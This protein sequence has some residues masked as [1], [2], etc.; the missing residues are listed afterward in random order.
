M[1]PFELA[2]EYPLNDVLPEFGTALEV[3]PGVRWVRL[4][5][6]FALDHINVWLIRDS[7]D[8][9]DGWTLV[10]CGVARD[11]LKAIWQQVF[12]QAL[13]G[14][15]IVRI[16]ATHMH[17]D[18]VGLADWIGGRFG[19][20]LWMTL[21]EYTTARLYSEG[22]VQGGAT[23]GERSAAFYRLHGLTDPDALD[24]IRARAAY[25]SSLVPRVPP[26][27]RRIMHG[28]HIQ[29]GGYT[30]RVKVG[31]GHSPEHASLFCEELN[32]L[33]SGDMV[34]PR[35]SSNVSVHDDEPD[36]NPVELYLASLD[37]YDDIP[38]DA[39]ILPSH[40]KPFRGVHIRIEQQRQH[41]AERLAEVRAA[42]ATPKT[43]MEIVPLMFTRRLDLHQLTFALGEAV[44]HLNLLYYAGELERIRE[45]GTIR[46]MAA[47]R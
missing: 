25:Y 6:P 13:D 45:N 37:T 9:R 34:L 10:D 15:P 32:T 21:S 23:G 27:F 39:L 40:G 35:I 4:P 14:L 30:W 29:I 1:N 38:A 5:L 18:H 16:I 31:Y 8:G 36:G 3:A 42:C 47:A 43:A 44:A 28:D 11:E 26:S 41:H 7:F 19:A 33:I 46:F 20:P 12:A 22:R 17:P 2:L 24:K